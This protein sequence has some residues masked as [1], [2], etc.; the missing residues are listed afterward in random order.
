MAFAARMHVFPGGG[1]DPRDCDDDVPWDGPSLVQWAERLEVSEP[2]ASGL[3]CAAVRELFEECGVLLAGR[4]GED[5]V[6]DLSDASWEDDRLALLDRSLALSELL[7]RRGLELRTEL[8]SAWSHWC[9]PVFEPRRYDTWFFVAALPEGQA[10]RHVEGEADHST[11]LGLSE[12]AAGGR[13]GSLAML[14][15]TMVTLDE[16]ADAPD[17]AS[18]LARPRE[19]RLLMPWLVRRPEGLSV[20]IDLDG[21]GGGEPG[22]QSGIE[23]VA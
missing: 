13:D 11:W 1:V 19:P 4:P 20:R 14:P 7:E 9:T 2:E 12:A 17:V 15:P 6:G 23:D 5:V 22:P 16:L 21:R 10:A 3:V 8:L 18:V